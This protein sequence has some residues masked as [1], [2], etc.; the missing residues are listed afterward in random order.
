LIFSHEVI[1]GLLRNSELALLICLLSQLFFE[2]LERM[3]AG[4]MG[5]TA[6]EFGRTRAIRHREKVP[7]GGAFITD[8]KFIIAKQSFLRMGTTA[9]TGGDDESAGR[10]Q[11]NFVCIGLPV[12]I[13]L[14]GRKILPY[15]GRVWVD[16]DLDA[17]F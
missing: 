17:A 1:R 16:R 2:V 12:W 11:R 10:W 9:H 14:I 6:R 7:A 4:Q 13:V 5:A 3:R 8:A 15:R